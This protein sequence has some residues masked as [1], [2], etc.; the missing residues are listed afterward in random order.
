MPFEFEAVRRIPIG[1]PGCEDRRYWRF[2]SKGKFTVKSGYRVGWN[3]VEGD[4]GIVGASNMYDDALCWSKVWSL[5][6]PPKIKIFV[7]KL[8]LEILPI[9]ANLCKHHVPRHPDCFVCGVTLADSAHVLFFCPSIRYIW[10][11]Y[12]CWWQLKDLLGVGMRDIL[13]FCSSSLNIPF[14]CLVIIL[15]GIWRER[16]RVQHDSRLSWGEKVSKLEAIDLGW[17]EKFHT[18]YFKAQASSKSMVLK[19]AVNVPR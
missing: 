9:E 10:K 1:G 18:F 5:G 3:C 14:Y 17:V 12:L 8:A 7:W 16:C 19:P 15:W 11:R 4:P 13:Q 2:H 6:V